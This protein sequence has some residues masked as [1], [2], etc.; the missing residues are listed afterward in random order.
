MSDSPLFRAIAGVQRDVQR[1]LG[2]LVSV[3]VEQQTGTEDVSGEP[4]FGTPVQGVE[5]RIEGIDRTR[6]GGESSE[7]TPRFKVTIYDPDLT[8]KTEDRIT[9]DGVAHIVREV[10]GLVQNAM[11]GRY[12]T[13]A[14]VD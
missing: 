6:V 1:A 10:S 4:S 14:L 9:W 5:A 12:V 7:T 13:T 2:T 11:G 8:V 3:T